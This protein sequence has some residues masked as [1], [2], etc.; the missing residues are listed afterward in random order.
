[1]LCAPIARELAIVAVQAIRVP[2]GL[3]QTEWL[4]RILDIFIIQGMGNIF[5]AILVAI[6]FV[7]LSPVLLP[8]FSVPISLLDYLFLWHAFDDNTLGD[9][10]RNWFVT[11]SEQIFT[12]AIYVWRLNV[13]IFRIRPRSVALEN[14]IEV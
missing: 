3:A 8:L 1:M 6:L 9:Q 14:D 11:V 12:K 7:C 10:A 5:A 13:S 2:S 4:H